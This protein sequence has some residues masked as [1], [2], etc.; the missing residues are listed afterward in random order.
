MRVEL[1]LTFDKSEEKMDEE[2]SLFPV[3]GWKI[4]AIPSHDA[5][6]FSFNFLTTARQSPKDAD[7]SHHFVMTAE[8]AQEFIEV[9]SK[10]LEELQKPDLQPSSSLK[11]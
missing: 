9:I 7:I 10:S 2:L 4:G 3:V 5:V 1:I 8:A 6:M 11:H